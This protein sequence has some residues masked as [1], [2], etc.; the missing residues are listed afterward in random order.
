MKIAIFLLCYN[1]ELIIEKTVKHYRDRFP[2]S[3]III[4]DNCSTD[5]SVRI[6]IRNK[7]DVIPFTS[8]NQQ[9]EAV[10]LNIRNNVWKIA[11]TGWIIM[12]DMDEWLEITEKEL[13]E[14][15]QKG[16]TIIKTKGYNIIG[17]SKTTKLDDINLFE[18][19]KGVYDVTMS[20]NVLFKI[21]DVDICYSW[22]A[23]Q[24]NPKGTVKY[25][26]KE[27][28]LKH[29]NWLGEE[30]IVEKYRLRCE[31]NQINRHKDFFSFN[32]HYFTEKNRLIEM[33]REFDQNKT[34]III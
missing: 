17:D 8:G 20:K 9:N 33:Y 3:S 4:V 30:Y 21:P 23:H 24:C 16:T 32:G 34:K 19:N 31:R 7:W 11:N 25:S 18:L 15:D 5:N 12:A 2:S 14:E 13:E 22:G 28:I 29:M 6:A 1:E 27:Y 10:L 26:D